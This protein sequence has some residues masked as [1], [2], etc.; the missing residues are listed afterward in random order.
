MLMPDCRDDSTGRA[1]LSL[2]TLLSLLAPISGCGGSKTTGTDTTPPGSVSDLAAT[3]AT[4]TTLTLGWTA[5]G[6]DGTTGTAAL[7]DV[8]VS[9]T[10]LDAG[11][12]EAAPAALAPTPQ[13]AGSAQTMT[14]T[15]L[16]PGTHYYVALRTFDEADNASG[17]SNV[18][19]ADTQPG[20]QPHQVFHAT[21]DGTGS[22]CGSLQDCL[23]A[24]A[25]GDTVELGPAPG[26][27]IGFY[28]KPSE[29]LVDDG[30]GNVVRANM[31]ARSGVVI[32][33]AHGATV[34]VDGG[35][36][37]VGLSIPEGTARVTLRGIRFDNCGTG[38]RI[39][40]GAHTV[41]DCEFVTGLHGL[42]A[43]GADL[44][45]SDTKFME[46]G[47]E[48]VVARD[49]SGTFSGCE[50]WGNNYGIFAAQSRNL[51]FDRVIMA[52]A[53]LTGV[54]IEEG[55]TAVLSRMTI[56][57]AGM[58]PQD[59]TAVVV[60]GGAAATLHRCVISGNR[61]FGVHCRTGGTVSVTC[62][63]FF[64][65]TAGNFEGCA[66]PTGTNGVIDLDP[67]FC[68]TASLDFHLGPSSPART[69]ACGVM[70]AYGDAGCDPVT[71]ERVIA[72]S[73]RALVRR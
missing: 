12:F 28:T 16:D 11:N 2:V 19:E 18:V 48:A 40:G 63:D 34:R 14:I 59:S 55:G 35:G 9:K 62:S 49:C 70:G 44:D 46:Y 26:E 50:F 71:S 22:D 52:F 6:D 21:P 58:V 65:N 51:T 39:A 41:V 5:P 57:G 45:V 33:A 24:A 47:A 1:F 30:M 20:F 36:D 27:T 67:Q 3:A 53:C 25:D 15:G 31:V 8:R 10:A 43:D 72:R 61:G 29:T 42:V 7:Y 4:T 73:L 32:R 23:N 60:A 38:L 56:Y 54:R 64:A 13:A 37:R 69:A 68:D 66:D 17:I